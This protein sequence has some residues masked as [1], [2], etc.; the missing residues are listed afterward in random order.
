MS[1]SLP[2]Q[3]LISQMVPACA[4]CLGAT[5]SRQTEGMNAAVLLLLAVVLLVMV[6]L[7]LFGWRLLLQEQRN[8]AEADAATG[9]RPP[10]KG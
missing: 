4:A 10:C 7:V 3:A 2:L 6:G 8:L 9:E 5:D 1:A